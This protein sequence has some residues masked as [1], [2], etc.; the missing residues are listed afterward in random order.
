MARSFR[1]RHFVGT[2]TAGDKL[3]WRRLRLVGWL[4]KHGCQD[5]ADRRHVLG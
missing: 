4:G 2:E 5:F 1:R 3:P